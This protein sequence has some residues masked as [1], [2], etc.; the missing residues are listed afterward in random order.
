MVVPEPGSQAVLGLR[1]PPA[2]L[3]ALPLK[4]WLPANWWPISWAT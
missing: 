3:L 4:G 1:L 2:Q